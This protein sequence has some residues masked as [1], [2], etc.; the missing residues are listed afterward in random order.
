MRSEDMEFED[1]GFGD[2]EFGN[3]GLWFSDDIA[4]SRRA[5]IPRLAQRAATISTRENPMIVT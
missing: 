4:P 1:M 2:L 5:P 3:M